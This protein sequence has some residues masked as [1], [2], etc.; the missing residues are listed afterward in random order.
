MIDE[1]NKKGPTLSI[2]DNNTLD[3]IEIKLQNWREWVS[4]LL[5]DQDRGLLSIVLHW[6]L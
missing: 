4:A 1:F 2:S 3:M 5:K 6:V